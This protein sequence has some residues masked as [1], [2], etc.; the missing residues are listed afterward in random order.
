MKQTT[1]WTLL[2]CFFLSQLALAPLAAAP[3]VSDDKTVKADDDPVVYITEGGKKYHKKNCPLVKTG[4][5][6]IKLS[7]ALEKGYEPCKACNP[8][9]HQTVYVN[10]SGK[11]Y[12]KKGC[13]MVK[14]DAKPMTL[15]EAKK[16]ELAPCKLCHTETKKK[17][18]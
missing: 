18:D 11:V 10:P 6:G 13:K 9:A 8:P 7:E 15:A 12:H 17:D 5:K 2:V 3:S 14:K 16:A 1:L 4:K